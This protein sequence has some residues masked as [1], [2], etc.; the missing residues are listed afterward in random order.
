VAA[1]NEALLARAAEAKLLHTS[2]L[3]ADT[4]FSARRPQ[5]ETLHRQRP[6]A[7]PAARPRAATRT[8]QRQPVPR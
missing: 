3:H 4:I 1:C 5:C 6:A 2:R 7:R 8:R